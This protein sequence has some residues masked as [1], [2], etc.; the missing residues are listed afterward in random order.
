MGQGTILRKSTTSSKAAGGFISQ[1]SEGRQLLR[2]AAGVGMRK[3]QEIF[4]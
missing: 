3:E 2:R 4:L 1:V